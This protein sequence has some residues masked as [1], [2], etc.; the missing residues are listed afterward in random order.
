MDRAGK[1]KI[2]KISPIRRLWLKKRERQTDIET[3][4][5][6]RLVIHNEVIFKKSHEQII[7]L[8][9]NRS[10]RVNKDKK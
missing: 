5:A 4:I 8:I 9:Y 10:G 3:R 7:N 2:Y 6:E 1:M